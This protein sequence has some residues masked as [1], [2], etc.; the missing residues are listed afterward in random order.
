MPSLYIHKISHGEYHVVLDSVIQTKHP[1]LSG[2]EVG[3]EKAQQ[4]ID[5]A[6]DR[7]QHLRSLLE[8]IFDFASTDTTYDEVPLAQI[9]NENEVLHGIALSVGIY[10]GQEDWDAIGNSD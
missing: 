2:A 3:Q 8:N 10:T 7:N 1:M 4:M 6:I 5:N 9:L